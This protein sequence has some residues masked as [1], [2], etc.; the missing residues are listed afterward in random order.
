MGRTQQ[1]FLTL[2]LF[3]VIAATASAAEI[4]IEFLA[5]TTLPGDLEV[6]RTLVGGLS[7]LTYDP[8][9]DLFY[10]ISDDRGSID[11]PRFY[12]LK[13]RSD[14]SRAEAEVLGA[15]LL[16]D[17]NGEHFER[18]D[19][20]PEAIALGTDG[21]LFLSS[22]GVPHRG[23]EP[24]VARFGLDGTIRSRLDL[25]D[26]YVPGP[27]NSRG[28]R[29][30]HGFEGLSLNPSGGT[31][32]VATESALL[33]D[34]P[35]ADLDRGS[36]ARIMKIDL[37][38]GQVAGEYLYPVEPVPDV[39]VPA[40]AYASIGVSEI[41]ALDD[42]RV[43]VVER[44]FSA[45]VGN[46]VRL[47]L[48]D[49]A[50]APDIQH[51][52]SVSGVVHPGGLLA[53]KTLLVDLH[54]HGVDPDNIEGLALGPALA[55]GRR[56][57]VL[58]SDN[59][60]QPSVQENQVLLFAVSGVALP[61]AARPETA[62]HEIQGVGHV[63]PLVG[64]C[65]SQVEGIVTAVLGSRSG[66]AFWLQSR[67]PGDEDPRTSEGVFVTA[68]DGLDK[69]E[70]GDLVR[71]D[72]RVEERTWGLELPVTR[73]F[74]DVLEVDKRHQQLPLP[75]VLGG[76][77]VEIPQPEIGSPD[78]SELEPGRFAADAYE[79]LEGMLVRVE[80]PVVVGPTSRYG[81]IVVLPDGGRD[82][83]V[84]TNRG[85]I[86]LLEDNINP[87]RIVIDD[88]L[89]TP[90][91][92]LSVGQST[93]AAVDGVLHYS[94]GN[95]KV[96]NTVELPGFESAGPGP[97]RTD[98]S[99]D[100]LHL[101]VA[102]FN[103]ENLSA[104]SDAEKFDRL[105]ALVAGNLS[106]PDIVAVQEVQD[107]SGPSDD[108]T[109]TAARTLALLIEGIERAGGE[110][111]EARWIDPEDNADGGQPGGNI[112]TAFLFN[113]SRVEFLDRQGFRDGPGMQVADP[114]V[115]G[116]SPGLIDPDN[117]A[118]NK[119]ED[120]RGG[121][122]KP[123]VGEFRFAGKKIILVNLHLRSKGGDDPIFGRRQPRVEGSSG[124]R[125]E[126][127]TVVADYVDGLLDRDPEARVVVL[128]DLN[129]FESSDA[130]AVLER[131]GLEGL[132]ERLPLEVRYSYVY[133]GN[134]QVL[135]HILVS[136]A[137]AAGAEIDMVHVNAEYP[138]AKRAS[139]HDPI[140]VRLAFNP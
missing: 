92:D 98:L 26:H 72:G 101:T 60:F 62:I 2:L 59:N 89:V 53:P 30:N 21:I 111:Y 35:I 115:S 91:P 7:G 24:L 11:P 79:S 78:F 103:V 139:D 15:T 120:G 46:R 97:E 31:L 102:T 39:P 41:L 82:A 88:R 12:T 84:R 64:Q 28:V 85:G 123:L 109:V 126:Q 75:V 77:G 16:R 74:V 67:I 13:I 81:E 68:V 36:S 6:D 133:L 3:A 42:T 112:R 8:G 106:S 129:D 110:R 55:G 50:G 83:A 117:P 18:G 76:G 27:G 57:L 96:L 119:N 61:A 136:P 66:Q 128:G 14:G 90:P 118:F 9:C 99:G 34:G 37:A 17:S 23:V 87:Q 56:L 71:A 65:V 114:P 19:L 108:G 32:F 132:V 45:G 38:T 51:L 138:A 100:A 80:E 54:D 29:D 5:E 116:W 125:I 140:V 25:P 10:A 104:V 95:Y 86:R 1:T 69:V 48:V 47:Y 49:L 107:D 73:L 44:S 121:S 52:E 20:D 127:A 135:D 93:Q 33:Q 94:F 58:I 130:L 122:R 137:L 131:A 43:I 134:S 113:P 70:I 4:R 124:R 105:A 40:T 22:E 63:S